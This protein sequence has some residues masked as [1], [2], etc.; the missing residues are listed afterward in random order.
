M[1]EFSTEKLTITC[2]AAWLLEPADSGR[3]R[4][5]PAE[6]AGQRLRAHRQLPARGRRRPPAPRPGRSA[7]PAFS[8]TASTGSGSRVSSTRTAPRAKIRRGPGRVG[9]EPE[10]L[11]GALVVAADAE[12]PAGA[13]SRRPQPQ[14]ALEGAAQ[15]G[16]ASGAGR[17]AAPA[18]GRAARRSTPRAISTTPSQP[19]HAAV[20]RSRSH[21]TCVRATL[22]C[23]LGSAQLSGGPQEMLAVLV[24][25]VA[26]V[27]LPLRLG[28][29]LLGLRDRLISSAIRAYSLRIDTRPW[30]T[31]MNPPS[32]AMI[33]RWSSSVKITTAAR[34]QDGQH[35]RVPGQDADVA[36]DGLGDDVRRLAR[37][38]HPVGRDDL[39]LHRISHDSALRLWTSVS[40][41]AARTSGA[42]RRPCCRR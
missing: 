9:E 4:F 30:D 39:D 24:A 33:S 6:Q 23:F 7:G 28:Q 41:S 3:C 27:E 13:R 1:A 15:R 18:R 22:L 34:L 14:A 11:E 29:L 16:P 12:H 37:P 26:G 42:R 17:R 38:D 20:L 19:T 10:P 40:P 36:V 25:A 32:T 8:A 35:G 21:A 31:E 5:Q 2:H